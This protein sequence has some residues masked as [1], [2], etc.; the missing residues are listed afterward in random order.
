MKYYVV[1]K[2]HNPGIYEDWEETKLQVSGF[3]G[4][5]Y[6]GYNTV[7]EATEAYRNFT[8][9]ED[10][11]DIMKMMD[12]AVK[13][14]KDSNGNVSRDNPEV[15][16]DAWAVDASCRK[17][18]G[19]MEYRGVEL[20]TGKVIFQRGPYEDGTNN[21]GEFLALVHAMALMT[22]RGEYHNIYTDSETAMKWWKRRNPNTKLKPTSKN[23]RIF[24]LM[25]RAKVWINTHQFPAK[26]MKWQTERW[27]EIP[28]DFGRKH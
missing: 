15:D 1:F 13:E 5:S 24:D 18:P 28:A 2:G 23:A 17:N 11:E 26:V 16:W 27:G 9:A 22:Q 4:A 10:M 6:K 14:T 19:P 7:E 12:A 3:P 21:I 8:A 25:A 20:K